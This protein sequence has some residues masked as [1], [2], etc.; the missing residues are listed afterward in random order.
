MSHEGT[1]SP[2]FHLQSDEL[3]QCHHPIA[4]YVNNVIRYMVNP[5]IIDACE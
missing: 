3:D 1:G 2:M 4:P 5:S